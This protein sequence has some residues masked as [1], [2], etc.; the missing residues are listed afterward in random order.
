VEEKRGKERSRRT[1]SACQLRWRK[2]GGKDREREE[3][4]EVLGTSVFVS[5][6][7]EKV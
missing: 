4:E 1:F 2:S 5:R 7:R 3:K 6:K